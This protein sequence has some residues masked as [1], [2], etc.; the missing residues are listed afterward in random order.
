MTKLSTLRFETMKKKREKQKHEK[1]CDV[2]DLWA[3]ASERIVIFSSPLFVFCFF[4]FTRV[5][6]KLFLRF[7]RLNTLY[8]ILN[9]F[10]F[11]GNN[12][13]FQKKRKN[14]S[15]APFA[16]I[17]WNLQLYSVHFDQTQFQWLRLSSSWNLLHFFS[18]S[19]FSLWLGWWWWG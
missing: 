17:P 2:I 10:T 9:T 3:R 4:H 19:I 14:Y 8:F 18:F 5:Y 13:K 6:I 16:R 15:N 11:K 1:E 7:Y 12:S